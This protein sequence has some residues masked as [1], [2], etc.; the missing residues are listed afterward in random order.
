MAGVEPMFA[1]SD[2]QMPNTNATQANHRPD[3]AATVGP[4]QLDR[5][6]RQ[7]TIDQ[8]RPDRRRHRIRTDAECEV[9]SVAIRGV[10]RAE[11]NQPV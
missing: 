2:R 4:P 7:Q 8:K 1:T 11:G 10:R 5:R 3:P 6:D 9:R